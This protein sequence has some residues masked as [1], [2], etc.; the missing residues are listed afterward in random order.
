MVRY[1]NYNQVEKKEKLLVFKLD[2]LQKHVG[3]HKT[4]FA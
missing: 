1:T 4:T 2:G 3:C